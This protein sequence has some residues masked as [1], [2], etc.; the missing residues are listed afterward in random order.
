MK[1]Q[2]SFNKG[3]LLA[4]D[5]YNTDIVLSEELFRQKTDTIG[6]VRKDRRDLPNSVLKFSFKGLEKG[7][8]II[9]Y[10]EEFRVMNWLDSKEVRILSS[11]G[12][13]KDIDIR[14]SRPNP[15]PNAAKQK[16]EMIVIYN[17]TMPGVDKND[18][19][20]SGRK[21]ARL[22]IKRYQ[23]KIFYHL[24]D[25]I[26]INSY[27][28][29]KNVTNGPMKLSHQEFRTMLID[30]IFKKNTNNP[31]RLNPS[32]DPIYQL[33]LLITIEGYAH[34]AHRDQTSLTKKECERNHGSCVPIVMNFC[35]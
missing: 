14:R 26:L 30:S 23:Q 22:R 8:R 11:V 13:A 21:V 4:T 12:T 16:P 2:K 10:N 17:Q 24:L 27:I 18:Q 34:I 32:L 31:S 33:P 20:K 3:H 29:L 1:K 5:N 25:V 15:N 9:K 19:M 28:Y 7:A 6:T 35:A